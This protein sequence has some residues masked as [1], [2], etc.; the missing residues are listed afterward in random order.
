[1]TGKYRHNIDPKGRLIVPAKLRD[2]LG[3]TFYVTMGLDGCLCIYTEEGWNDI[4]AKVNA[5]PRIQARKMRVLFANCAK[6]E[7]DRQNRFLLP[8]ELREYAH[9][10]DEVMFIGVGHYAE[11]WDCSTYLAQEAAQMT[12]EALGAAMAELGL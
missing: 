2:E 8:A 1:M 5:L 7:P 4:V 3:D 11:I 9:L 6:C 12:P 10:T